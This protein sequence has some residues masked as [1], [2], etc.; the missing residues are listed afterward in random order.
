[1][2]TFALPL[3]SSSQPLQ[4]WT[5]KLTQP[6]P[7]PTRQDA[8]HPHQATLDPTGRFVL[9]PDL[10]AD[11]IRLFRVDGKSGILE[12]LA[13]YS[14]PA[15]SG[16][17]HVAFYESGPRA[18]GG[19]VMYLVSELANSLTA[20]DV[21]YPDPGRIEFTARQGPVQPY[22]GGRAPNGSTVAEVQVVVS[23]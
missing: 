6:G 19:V 18:G 16:P 11:V 9:V 21:T 8:P 10:G 17:R 4:S 5:Y 15:G 3:S 14:V 22:P 7:N 13:D 12:P 2:S 1:M 23:G 20:F